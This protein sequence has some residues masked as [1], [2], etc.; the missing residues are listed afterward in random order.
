MVFSLRWSTTPAEEASL[1]FN[2]V[3]AF[4][5]V[6]PQ[7]QEELDGEIFLGFVH[8]LEDLSKIAYELNGFAS[9]SFSSRC[10]G[11]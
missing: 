5:A 10:A 11:I 6:R 4:E 2:K 1:V 9:L 3:T 7:L 8:Q